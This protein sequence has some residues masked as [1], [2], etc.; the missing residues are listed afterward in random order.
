MV[1]KKKKKKKK[2]K[3]LFFACCV[4][5]RKL[6]LLSGSHILRPQNDEGSSISPIE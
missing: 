1:K 6:Q 4:S 5:Y 2:T 3:K